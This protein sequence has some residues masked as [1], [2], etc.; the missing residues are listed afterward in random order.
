M[1]VI[2]CTHRRRLSLPLGFPNS[3]FKISKHSKS[4]WN[5]HYSSGSHHVAIKTFLIVELGCGYSKLSSFTCFHNCDAVKFVSGTEEDLE[6]AAEI[7]EKFSLTEKC[8]VYISPVF[9]SIDPKEIVDFMIRRKMN[10]VRLQLQLH[11]FIWDP[12][13]KGV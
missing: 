5:G 11:K 3:F 2:S 6:K 4:R 1:R 8:R 9:G 12:E 13:E 7:I 10:G